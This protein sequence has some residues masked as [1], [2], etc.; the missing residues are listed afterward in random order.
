M[1]KIDLLGV[2]KNGT[3]AQGVIAGMHPSGDPYLWGGHTVPH[4]DRDTVVALWKEWKP[5]G[6]DLFPEPRCR[7]K[8][9]AVDADTD[10]GIVADALQHIDPWAIGYHA[11]LGILGALHDTFGD[12]A[13]ELAA[14]WGD[15]GVEERW[16]SF[17]NYG[18]GGATLASVFYL[19]R[20]V[21][22]VDTRRQWFHE[23]VLRTKDW[24]AT[25]SAAQAFA[26][27]SVRYTTGR[28]IIDASPTLRRVGQAD[29]TL[30]AALAGI[31]HRRDGRGIAAPQLAAPGRWRH[32]GDRRT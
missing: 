23:N 32:G 14:E 10:L 9:V 29:R 12:A 3:H 11:W 22:W 6:E 8:N 16:G 26:D 20:Q 2:N 15:G 21:G 24:L 17:G 4:L 19:A 25:P 27:A 28:K 31:T 30:W 13:L 18:E 5:A 7:S 1:H